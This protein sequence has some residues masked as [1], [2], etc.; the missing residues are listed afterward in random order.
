MKTIYHLFICLGFA[1]CLSACGQNDSG[2]SNA[3]N[4][5]AAKPFMAYLQELTTTAPEDDE[6]LST[7]PTGVDLPE[8]AIPVEL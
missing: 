8:D 5:S 2:H 6:P 1:F 7:E 3:T 4:N